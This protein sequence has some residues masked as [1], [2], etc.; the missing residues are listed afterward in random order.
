[1]TGCCDWARSTFR[2]LPPH[3]LSPSSPFIISSEVP[4]HSL[5][6]ALSL[7]VLIITNHS[8]SIQLPP[9]HLLSPIHGVCFT[10][11]PSS[12]PPHP[13]QGGKS[14]VAGVLLFGV[15]P[16]MLGLLCDLIVFTPLRVPLD[17]TPVYF[18]STVCS[19]CHEVRP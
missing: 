11:S 16:L 15:I 17:R 8:P 12:P 18:L 4:S 5:T 10:Q 19:S 3:L 7:T 13:L 6:Q 9:Y 14:V 2:Q 1:M